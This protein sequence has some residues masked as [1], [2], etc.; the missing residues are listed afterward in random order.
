MN[1]DLRHSVLAAMLCCVGVGTGHGQSSLGIQHDTLVVPIAAMPPEVHFLVVFGDRSYDSLNVTILDVRGPGGVSLADD[2]V[3]P[4]PVTVLT[5]TSARVTLDLHLDRLPWHGE[6][7]VNL[8]LD[9]WRRA[10]NN[11]VKNTVVSHLVLVRPPATLDLGKSGQWSFALSRGF[12]TRARDSVQLAVVENSG[13]ADVRALTVGSHGLRT[14]DSTAAITGNITVRATADIVPARDSVGLIV[15][16]SD[17]K[18]GHAAA[19]IWTRSPSLSEERIISLDVTV[20]DHWFWVLLMIFIGACVGLGAR[21]L[22]G[23]LRPQSQNLLQIQL[24]R[25]RIR[26]LL[27][28]QNITKEKK[29]TLETCENKLW[30]AEWNNSAGL[31]NKV[32]QLLKDIDTTLA[33]ISRDSF[34]LKQQFEIDS[35]GAL[36]QARS[37]IWKTEVAIAAIAIVFALVGGYLVLYGEQWGG[38]TDWVKAIGWGLSLDLGTKGLAGLFKEVG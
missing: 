9:G 7:R 2:A 35:K 21:I 1:R 28:N 13:V 8:Q 15:V 6:Y 26:R 31:F 23:V 3:R 11:D 4:R 34:G 30:E 19:S 36:E 16:L 18:A 24:L 17:L 10:A 38:V 25:E 37:R 5:S 27:E 14:A 22:M 33:S 32:D 12:F 20:S 29:E